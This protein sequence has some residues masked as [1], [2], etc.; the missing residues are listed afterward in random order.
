MTLVSADWESIASR[1]QLAPDLPAVEMS[2][3]ACCREHGLDNVPLNWMWS[4]RLS[5][6][7]A[8]TLSVYLVFP[9]DNTEQE[10][11]LVYSLDIL[12]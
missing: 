10:M 1:S 2:S 8:M 11:S 12:L 6:A 7:S 5:R 3:W 9:H 4:V